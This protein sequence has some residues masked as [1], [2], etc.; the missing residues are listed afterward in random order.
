MA[1]E[2]KGLAASG[3]EQGNCAAARAANP[4]AGP[5]RAARALARALPHRALVFLFLAMLWLPFLGMVAFPERDPQRFEARRPAPFPRISLDAEALREFPSAFEAYFADRL[6]FRSQLVRLSSVIRVKGLGVSTDERVLLGKDSWL[7]MAHWPIPKSDS[8]LR[9]H[10]GARLFSPAELAQ[11]ETVLE[12]RRDALAAR[13]MRYLFVIVPH[14][15]SIYPE[16]LPDYLTSVG[17][18]TPTDQLVAHLRANSDLAV[19]DLRPALRAAKGSELL[20]W[21][22]DTH[23]TDLGAHVGYLEI[24]R[25]L[26]Q[27]FPAL[28][29]RPREAFLEKV[30]E[31]RGDLVR[32]L[33]LGG[34][35]DEIGF[36]LAPRWGS[37]ARALGAEDLP[38][39]PEAERAK[40]LKVSE[41]VDPGLP[42]AV[43]LHDSFAFY[44]MPFLSEHFSRVVYLRRPGTRAFR[45]GRERS[46]PYLTT[47]IDFERPD[48]VIDQV[49]ER[50]L[51]WSYKDYE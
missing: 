30:H 19:L 32:A 27:W 51:I 13:G 43:V 5:R 3:N 40:R 2:Q 35:D 18:L 12:A 6:G 44:L 50:N 1:G 39:P 22:T 49:V 9:Q 38:L 17:K 33:G 36:K 31:E 42:R 25:V 4:L 46:E 29:P 48:V 47:L 26:S 34:L 41:V 21:R 16:F 7:F 28:R 14:K 45:D 23:W 10:R 11:W 15:H 24:M 8:V 20:Y 37:G